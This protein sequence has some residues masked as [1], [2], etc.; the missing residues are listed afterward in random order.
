MVYVNKEWGVAAKIQFATTT[1]FY[2]FMFVWNQRKSD[3]SRWIMRRMVIIWT[4]NM[5]LR[6][7]AAKTALKLL[8][9]FNLALCVQK[10]PIRM[11]DPMIRTFPRPIST[12]SIHDADRTR[13]KNGA[14]RSECVHNKS[15]TETAK[16]DDLGLEIRQHSPPFSSA[17]P[18]LLFSSKF[19]VIWP[20]R[21]EASWSRRSRI[22]RAWMKMQGRRLVRRYLLGPS[23]FADGQVSQRWERVKQRRR[24]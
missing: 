7:R 12:C 9:G 10:P 15:L 3:A 2:F 24:D 4:H 23:D 8:N 1:A 14:T 11:S 19:C 17:S 6:Y 16:I 18:F 22:S 20:K 13:A 5:Y 21:M